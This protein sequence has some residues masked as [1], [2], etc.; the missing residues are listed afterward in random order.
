M[1]IYS[2]YRDDCPEGT[3]CD[4]ETTT[5]RNGPATQKIPNQDALCLPHHKMCYDTN[6]ALCTRVYLSLYSMYLSL[7]QAIRGNMYVTH[8][9]ENRKTK[10]YA[11]QCHW[12]MCL[13]YLMQDSSE[14]HKECNHDLIGNSILTNLDCCNL[15][16]KRGGGVRPPRCPNKPVPCTLRRAF[17]VSL[18]ADIWIKDM[19][20]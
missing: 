10:L 12:W 17:V 14:A 1:C 2:C 5:I 7:A 20:V 3:N 11:C 13:E 19:K 18:Y 8:L 16:L 9:M 6:N 4:C 15:K